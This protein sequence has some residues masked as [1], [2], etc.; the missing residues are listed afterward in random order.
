M[1]T[2]TIVR[3]PLKSTEVVNVHCLSLDL[4]S[5][6]EIKKQIHLDYESSKNI[7]VEKNALE[8]MNLQENWRHHERM[9]K[10]PKY[11]IGGSVESIFSQVSVQSPGWTTLKSSKSQDALESN[12]SFIQNQNRPSRQSEL[13]RQEI[14]D[15]IVGDEITFKLPRQRVQERKIDCSV[16]IANVSH[17]LS[18]SDLSTSK[19]SASELLPGAE[20]EVYQWK[21]TT[22]LSPVPS[23]ETESNHSQA[24]TFAKET[25]PQDVFHSFDPNSPLV[26]Q[27]QILNLKNQIND[28]QEA[29]ESAVLELSKADEEISQQRKDLAKLTA[30]YRQKLKDSQEE[31]KVLT[32][33]M[34]QISSRFPPPENYQEDLLKEIT[35]LRIECRRLR[36][37]SHQLSEENHHLKEYLWDLK[38][39]HQHLLAGRT[40]GVGTENDWAT[41]LS[42]IPLDEKLHSDSWRTEGNSLYRNDAINVDGTLSKCKAALGSVNMKE[43]WNSKHEEHFKRNSSPYSLNSENTE[44]LIMASEDDFRRSSH[45]DTSGGAW[46]EIHGL[47]DDDDLSSFRENI[48][49]NTL[50]SS[51]TSLHSAA[52]SKTAAGKRPH[53]DV[54]P[55][56]P[57]APKSVADL[58]LGN[59]VKFSRPGGKISKGTVQYK[60]HLPGREELYLGVE[61]EGGELGKHD[62]IFQGVRYFLCKPN[63]GVFVN[64]RKIIMAWT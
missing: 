16:N 55:R 60:G 20:G 39:Q 18:H 11:R 1:E 7:F 31:I 13:K 49:P 57:F 17:S 36:T 46:E 24:V 4:N 41:S 54:L 38:M 51:K 43:P 29:N 10:E 3:L 50:H 47:S 37:Q 25:N 9:K 2:N 23:E 48:L 52:S 63:K 14:I 62:G 5:Y 32:E 42:N 21:P 15:D 61:L 53:L 22:D 27:R 35:Q 58:K 59:F 26:L 64:F 30:E 6:P 56:R 28:L 33:K 34:S 44:V 12:T 40:D 45:A 19:M 8:L